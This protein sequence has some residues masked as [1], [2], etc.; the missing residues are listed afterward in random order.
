M[1]STS[2]SS[3]PLTQTLDAKGVVGK[4][5]EIGLSLDIFFLAW[6]KWGFDLI[7][8]KE[9]LQAEGFD[10][11]LPG[12]EK[13]CLLLEEFRHNLERNLGRQCFRGRPFPLSLPIVFPIVFGDDHHLTGRNHHAA[14]D[15]EQLARLSLLFLDLCRPPEERVHWTG[16]EVKD[17][18]PAYKRQL[19]M[20]EY[21]D[22]TTL[23]KRL[24]RS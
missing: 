17:L 14:V 22:T 12:K 8:L 23:G 4:L 10:S 18:G 11:I 16:T 20:E 7:F 6:A 5:Q 3:A 13:V 9:W 1:S 19:C 2:S 21:L 15:A 24:R